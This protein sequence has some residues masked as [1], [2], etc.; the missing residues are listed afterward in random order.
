MVVFSSRETRGSV[1]LRMAMY[2]RRVWVLLLQRRGE[3]ER[4]T[5]QSLGEMAR[6]KT[7]SC[8]VADCW[9][10]EGRTREIL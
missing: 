1:K 4:E 8:N 3:M 6:G 5:H 9:P 7:V 10:M 2:E